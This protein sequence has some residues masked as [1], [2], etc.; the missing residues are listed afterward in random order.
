MELEDLNPER[1]LR[2]VFSFSHEMC[3]WLNVKLKNILLH[4]AVFLC[5][6]CFVLN[7]G[8]LVRTNV[9][10]SRKSLSEVQSL[11]VS[12]DILISYCVIL[13]VTTLSF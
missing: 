8:S 9:L 11:L 10:D 6:D 12:C 1:F 4:T 3:D 13:A 2:V 7:T 5:H